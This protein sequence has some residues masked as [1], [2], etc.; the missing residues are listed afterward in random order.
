MGGPS[1][2]I[3]PSSRCLNILSRTWTDTH[4]SRK[5]NIASPINRIDKRYSTL[6]SKK[7]DLIS[8]KN[9]GGTA[10]GSYG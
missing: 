10:L 4:T 2:N 7:T 8:Y 9:K 3:A 1:V 5:R 6:L